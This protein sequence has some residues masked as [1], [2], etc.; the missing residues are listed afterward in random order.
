LFKRAIELQEKGMSPDAPALAPTLHEYA[1]LCRLQHR[2]TE[3]VALDAKA[4]TLMH[5]ALRETA[6]LTK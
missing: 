4:K 5:A 6:S 2:S 3:A 1:Q